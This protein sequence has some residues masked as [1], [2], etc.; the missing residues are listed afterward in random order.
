MAGQTVEI[1]L[2]GR[3]QEDVESIL[4]RVALPARSYFDN[5]VAVPD[6]TFG[7]QETRGKLRVVPGCAHRDGEAAAPDAN[8]KG[9]LD[10]DGVVTLLPTLADT[11]P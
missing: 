2:N 6:E 4:G 5:I 7:Q 8:F 11:I 10:G 3:G 1:D 9:F